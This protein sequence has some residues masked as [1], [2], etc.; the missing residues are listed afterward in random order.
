MWLK[1]GYILPNCTS[2]KKVKAIPL[3]DK[4]Q[5]K[6]IRYLGLYRKLRA[7]APVKTT[8]HPNNGMPCYVSYI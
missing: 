1:T 5:Q 2:Q 3:R 4:W 8:R 7:P 6:Y